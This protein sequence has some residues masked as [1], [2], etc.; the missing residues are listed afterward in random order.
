MTQHESGEGRS[1]TP[2][3]LAELHRILQMGAPSLVG[4]NA[5]ERIELP[6]TVYQILKDVVGNM[7]SGKAVV[8]IAEDA[9]LS[10]QMAA[11]LLG[12][13]R[14]HFIKLVEAG[15]IPYTTTGSHRRVRLADV[16]A[17]ARKRDEE[18]RGILNR[19]ARESLEDGSY[20]GI[21]LPE[22]GHDE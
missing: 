8:V 17:Y 14:P 16:Q 22:G 13:S 19:L 1:A 9:Q 20:V 10:T 6:E 2:V 12:V 15:V 18:R 3:Q 11:D 7:S 4:A 5:E 21:A